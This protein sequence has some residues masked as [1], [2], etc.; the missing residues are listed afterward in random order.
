MF[1]ICNST[2][3]FQ[4]ASVALAVLK[5]RKGVT[6]E[7][8]AGDDMDRPDIAQSS[9]PYASFGGEVDQSYQQAPFSGADTSKPPPPSDYQPPTY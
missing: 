8:G 4:G 7:F 3:F 5:Y 6:E 1:L 2:N 9:N